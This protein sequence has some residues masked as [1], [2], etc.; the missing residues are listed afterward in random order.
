M[1]NR[2]APEKP[3]WKNRDTPAFVKKFSRERYGEGFHAD[4]V[5]FLDQDAGV[6]FAVAAAWLF[7]PETVEY[8][9]GIFLRR[10][11]FPGNVDTWLE[12]HDLT[13]TQ[14]IVNLTEIWALFTNAQSDV[15]DDQDENALAS[16]LAECWYGVIQQ[17]HPDHRIHVS[18]DLDEEG[19]SAVG[20][21]VTVWSSGA[22]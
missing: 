22:T 14:V 20:P 1:S 6:A 7:C 19:T 11:F 18:V 15:F 17:R 2:E 12:T 4:P 10:R 5:D 16:A 21:T 13:A 3:E 9:D 8:R